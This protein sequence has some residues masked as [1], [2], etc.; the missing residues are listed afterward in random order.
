MEEKPRVGTG[1]IILREGKI[2]L[3][4]RLGEHGPGRWTPPGG[5]LE[6]LELVEDC[7]RREAEEETG[8]TLPS[9]RF[10]TYTDDINPDKKL[11]FVT[12]H[13]V[14]TDAL[15]DP[16]VTEPDKFETWQWF[17]WDALPEPLFWPFENLIKSGYKPKI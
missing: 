12:M 10:L 16:M 15:G 13:F 7:A 1:I 5:K 8:M 3:G 2:L 11:H 4:K 17:D 6:M 14:C 9:L